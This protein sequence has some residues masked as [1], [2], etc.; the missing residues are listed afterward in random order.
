MVISYNICKLHTLIF[1]HIRYEKY[2][3]CVCFVIS[4]IF[5]VDDTMKQVCIRNYNKYISMWISGVSY[6]TEYKC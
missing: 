3:V 2:C 1:V 5:M 4:S 6:I